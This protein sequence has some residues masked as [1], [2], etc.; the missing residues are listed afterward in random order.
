MPQVYVRVTQLAYWENNVLTIDRADWRMTGFTVRIYPSL[1]DFFDRTNGTFMGSFTNEPDYE[2]NFTSSAQVFDLIDAEGRALEIEYT[3]ASP[4]FPNPTLISGIVFGKFLFEGEIREPCIGDT[5][6]GNTDG[7][8]FCDDSDMCPTDPNNADTDNDGVCDVDD[9]CIGDNTSGNTD[10]DEFCDDSDLCPTDPNNE[11]ADD[12]GLCDVDDVCIGDNTTG[13]IDGDQ[14]C[15]DLDLCFGNDATGDTDDD[16]VCDDSDNCPNDANA[17]Q[18]DADG[19]TIG[20]VCEADSDQD[21]TIN[22]EDNCPNIA[23]PDQANSDGD[24]EGD[25]CDPDDDNDSVADDNDNCPLFAN[26]GQEDFDG[27]GQGDVCDGDGDGDG[28][29]DDDDLCPDTPLDVAI[30][31]DGCSGQQLVDNLGGPC[32]FPNRRQYLRAVVSTANAARKS[33]LITRK[34]K[35]AIVRAAV[36]NLIG[37]ICAEDADQDGTI[38]DEDNCPNDAN[39]DQ[40][41]SDGDAEEMSVIRTMIM[42]RWPTLTTI[43][44][45]PPIPIKK[46]PMATA[47]EMSV[48]VMVTVTVTVLATKMTLAPGHLLMSQSVPTV[49][50]ASSLSIMLAAPATTRITSST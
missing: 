15:D 38:D 41:N 35:A 19:D 45:C 43:A 6:S 22:D 18:A 8:E 23:N 16:L 7:D 13:D 31:A 44:R 11:D 34:E 2:F 42:T 36:R 9:V 27:D 26:P 30:N 28:V 10:G 4:A 48:K 33:G 12:D 1:E 40:A 21:G 25:L 17:D 3:T 5:A 14:I 24:A 47:R 50:P 46:T 39:T 20:D 29:A 49:V 37:T 32:D